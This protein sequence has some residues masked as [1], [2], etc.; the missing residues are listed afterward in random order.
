MWSLPSQVY[1]TKCFKGQV[2]KEPKTEAQ[3]EG[4]H[5]VHTRCISPNRHWSVWA[6]PGVVCYRFFFC[7]CILNILH[8]G[9]YS[10]ASWVYWCV[11]NPFLRVRHNLSEL[12]SVSHTKQGPVAGPQGVSPGQ[13][14]QVPKGVATGPPPSSSQRFVGGLPRPLAPLGSSFSLV[15]VQSA[16][17]PWSGL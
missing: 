7:R 9:N 8:V 14:P 15:V 1:R 11:W 17:G 3:A 6:R 13:A 4:G 16:A 12:A 10:C 2:V 5:A